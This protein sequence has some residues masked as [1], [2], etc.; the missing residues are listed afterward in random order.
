MLVE[1][2]KKDEKV[3]NIFE[4]VKK[5]KKTFKAFSFFFHPKKNKEE[6]EIVFIPPIKNK[7]KTTFQKI[8]KN[9]FRLLQ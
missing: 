2:A 1:R 6:A 4:T 7:Y 5:N 3:Q 9:Q 8:I